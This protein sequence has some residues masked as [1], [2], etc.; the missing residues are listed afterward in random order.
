MWG[1]LKPLL[2]ALLQFFE[3]QAAKPRTLEDANTP[4]PI[5]RSW[6]AYLRDK[7]RDKDGGP[8]QPG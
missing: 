6:A 4:E 1:W 2:D 7:L 5:R 3:R 8:G